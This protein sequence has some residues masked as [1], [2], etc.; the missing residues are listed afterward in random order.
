MLWCPTCCWLSTALARA[1]S[2]ATAFKA[3]QIG[4][5]LFRNICGPFEFV[6]RVVHRVGWS[7]YCEHRTPA[8]VD[9]SALQAATGPRWIRLAVDAVRKRRLLV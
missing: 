6:A 5:R 8:A 1:G 4:N 9:N 7:V 3:Q 2:L